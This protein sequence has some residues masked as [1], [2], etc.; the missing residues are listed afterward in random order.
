MCICASVFTG[1]RMLA[2]RYMLIR[3]KNAK[4]GGM[5]CAARAALQ[6]MGKLNEV[7]DE[8]VKSAFKSS[9]G[10]ELNTPV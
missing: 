5:C 4:G 3:Q 10:L 1:M 9:E 2:C 7:T 6:K 8:L